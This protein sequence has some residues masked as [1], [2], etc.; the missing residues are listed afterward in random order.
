MNQQKIL[1]IN[2]FLKELY[3]N[4]GKPMI[5]NL[6]HIQKDIQV[7]VMTGISNTTGFGL[8]FHFIFFHSLT[9]TLK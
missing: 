5:Y 4:E 2:T 6:I 7:F 8:N 1:S 9:N 3:K